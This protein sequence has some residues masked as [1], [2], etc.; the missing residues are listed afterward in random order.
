MNAALIPQS[1]ESLK[2][3]LAHGAG[4]ADG[5]K[6]IVDGLVSIIRNDPTVA[7]QINELLVSN[8]LATSVDVISIF[9]SKWTA[10]LGVDVLA[11]LN[12]IAAE[13]I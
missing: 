2:Y 4:G 11:G 6:A 8:P 12:V 5:A 1:I 13:V 10:A 7:F 3:A 9:V